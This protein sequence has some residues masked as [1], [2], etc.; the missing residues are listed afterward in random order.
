MEAKIK[1]VTYRFT[2]NNLMLFILL[3]IAEGKDN[4]TLFGDLRQKLK[5]K[6]LKTLEEGG[7]V[8]ESE[9]RLNLLTLV[10]QKLVLREK[11]LDPI[12]NE[13]EVLRINKDYVYTAPKAD[14]E[15]KAPKLKTSNMIPVIITPS[16]KLR[17][18]LKVAGI[19]SA[20]IIKKTAADCH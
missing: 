15:K 1:G 6:R 2:M 3:H 4:S 19:N 10:E 11:G 16:P 9:F 14:A 7:S 17:N 18:D 5:L 8:F 13:G 12:I 20:E